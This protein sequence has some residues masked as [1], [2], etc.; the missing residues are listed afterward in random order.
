MLTFE[1]A[2]KASTIILSDLSQY[3]SIPAL[4]KKAGAN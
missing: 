1:W 3:D 4:A 2:E